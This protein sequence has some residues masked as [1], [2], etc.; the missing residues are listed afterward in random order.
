MIFDLFQFKFFLVQCRQYF[1]ILHKV[2]CINNPHQKSIMLSTFF[3]KEHLL[4]THQ[5][6]VQRCPWGDTHQ[7][8][9]S[10]LVDANYDRYQWLTV[11]VFLHRLLQMSQMKQNF[12]LLIKIINMSLV[13]NIRYRSWGTNVFI[14]PTSLKRFTFGYN[15]N[16]WTKLFK[17]INDNMSYRSS[18]FSIPSFS[19]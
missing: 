1:L 11:I 17:V 6:H 4:V 12:S 3:R 19:E 8:P 15:E 2:I 14:V 10:N 13:H 7:I 18:P 9:K 16:N 5:F